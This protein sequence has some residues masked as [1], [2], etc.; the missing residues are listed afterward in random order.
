MLPEYLV[1][2]ELLPCWIPIAKDAAWLL[3]LLNKR[4]GMTIILISHNPKICAG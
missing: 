3:D 1:L 4:E 2:D